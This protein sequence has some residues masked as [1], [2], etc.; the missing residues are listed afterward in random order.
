MSEVNA[1]QYYWTS[2]FKAYHYD[3]LPPEAMA[4]IMELSVGGVGKVASE[5]RKVLKSKS[6]LDENCK[7]SV[8]ITECIAEAVEKYLETY[9]VQHFY[10]AMCEERARPY[11]KKMSHY[12][13]AQ[14]AKGLTSAYAACS[15]E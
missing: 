5:L 10:D 1:R 7:Y 4:I 15:G 13:R 3:E 2:F 9:G 12:R 6:V 14:V 11:D 8:V